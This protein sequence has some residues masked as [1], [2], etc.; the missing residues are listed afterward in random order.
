MPQSGHGVSVCRLSQQPVHSRAPNPP[1]LL[2]LLS[3]CAQYLESGCIS[4][5][6]S[7]VEFGSCT[8]PAKEI[9]SVHLHPAGSAAPERTRRELSSHR[10][11]PAWP[12]TE[13]TGGWSLA[14]GKKWAVL[15]SYGPSLF[16]L[17]KNIY[18]DPLTSGIVLGFYG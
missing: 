18:Q 13:V 3:L 2:G 9:V 8:K 17:S 11:L 5:E 10:R 1:Q 6:A 7:H 14:A 16:V 15:S 4:R 12:W